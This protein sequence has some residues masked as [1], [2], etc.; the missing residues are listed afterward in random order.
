MLRRIASILAG[1]V[2]HFVPP[3]PKNCP[4]EVKQKLTLK[5]SSVMDNRQVRVYGYWSCYTITL[6]NTIT[7]LPEL[8]ADTFLSIRHGRCLLV[9]AV[10]EM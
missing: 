4:R 6:F 2:P 3:D 5:Q 1:F 7:K 9:Q 10:L 8:D